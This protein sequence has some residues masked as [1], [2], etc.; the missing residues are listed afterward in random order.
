M[1]TPTAGE[2]EQDFVSRCIPI[3][4]KEGLDQKQAAGKCY[5]MYRNAHKSMHPVA[6]AMQQPINPDELK[7]G[8]AHEALEHGLDAKSAVQ[9]AMDH[10]KE[11][12]NYY[13][14]LKA[15]GLM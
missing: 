3:V 7:S 2:S 9:M 6:M 1:P 11:H 4:M 12:P 14:E 5:G 13:S 10:L 8:A 15:A